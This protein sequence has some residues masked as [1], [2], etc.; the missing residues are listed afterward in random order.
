MS[1]GWWLSRAEAQ[2]TVLRGLRWGVGRAGMPGLRFMVGRAGMP[3]LRFMVGRR[4]VGL[5]VIGLVPIRGTTAN[6][7]PRTENR[8]PRTE[9]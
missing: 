2:A 4:G 6:R 8:E 1:C 9:N 7:E 3:G 5:S